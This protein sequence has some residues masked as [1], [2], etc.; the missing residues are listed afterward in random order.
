MSRARKE[1]GEWIPPA[2]L[3]KLAYERLD[4][5]D[6]KC[7]GCGERIGRWTGKCQYDYEMNRVYCSTG[8]CAESFNDRPACD[9]CGVF[10]NPFEEEAVEFPAGGRTLLVCQNCSENMDEDDL[11][12]GL[13]VL[14]P[15]EFPGISSKDK[16]DA[17]AGPYMVIGTTYAFQVIRPMPGGNFVRASVM[18]PT[19]AFKQCAKFNRE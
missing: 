10:I 9:E 4:D 2:Q 7:D 18:Q 1:E 17:A 13:H 12:E 3:K 6:R 19:T 5:V 8:G 11:T 15:H 14:Y 16:E